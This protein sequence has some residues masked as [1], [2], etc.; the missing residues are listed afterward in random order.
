MA[1]FELKVSKT[2]LHCEV[3]EESDDEG[4]SPSASRASRASRARRCRSSPP[5]DGRSPKELSFFHDEQEEQTKVYAWY[6]SELSKRLLSKRSV[7]ASP[8]SSSTMSFLP[9]SPT[10]AD[11]TQN[12][13][14]FG[15]AVEV[16]EAVLVPSDLQLPSGGSLGHP[17]A[18]RRPCIYF[19]QGNCENGDACV[20]CHLPHV[21]KTPKLDKRQRTIVQG[22]E[23]PELLGLVHSF[24]LAKAEE[25]G[26]AWE[27]AEILQLLEASERLTDDF[28]R[29][30]N[31]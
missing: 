14:G 20:Y 4:P 19:M 5:G 16:A 13:E 9:L 7:E 31:G 22:L 30:K 24:C 8:G 1:D 23:R 25:M 15:L 10:S 21:E 3:D 29:A 12:C 17:E 6:A 27:A 2:F 26:F 28:D 11:T 18:C